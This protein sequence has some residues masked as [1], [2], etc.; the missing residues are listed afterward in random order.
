MIVNQIK[1]SDE[2]RPWLIRFQPR[3]RGMIQH[4]EFSLHSSVHYAKKYNNIS[5]Y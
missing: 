1:Q 2:N 5:T 4:Q 3:K